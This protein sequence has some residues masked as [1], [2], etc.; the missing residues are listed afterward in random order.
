MHLSE[1]MKNKLSS[2]AMKFLFWKIKFRLAWILRHISLGQRKCWLCSKQII[3][4]W[5]P[6]WPA[7]DYWDAGGWCWKDGAMKSCWGEDLPLCKECDQREEGG[8]YLLD[9][10]MEFWPEE[11]QDDYQQ[12][13]DEYPEARS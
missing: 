4:L 11:E 1:K 10:C 13:I 7:C 6:L 3:G 2:D 12:W 5:H 8:V 9:A